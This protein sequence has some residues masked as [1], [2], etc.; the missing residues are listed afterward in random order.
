VRFEKVEFSPTTGPDLDFNSFSSSLGL[1]GSVNDS[2]SVSGLLDMSSRAPTA[3]ELYSNGPHLATNSF[4][5]G[6]TSLSEEDALSLTLSAAYTNDILELDTSV[7]TTKF[8]NYIYEVATDEELDELPVLRWRQDD[9]TFTGFNVKGLVD[10][11][12]FGGGDLSA[13]F[14]LDRVRGEIDSGS[15]LPR[16]PADRRGFGLSWDNSVWETSLDYLNVSNQRRISGFELPT[17][18]YKD[19][20]LFIQRKLVWKNNDVKLFLHGRNLTDEEQ[21]NHSS[22]VKDF[23]PAPGRSWELGVRFDF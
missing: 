19:L 15:D 12:S 22:I 3:E 9:A 11:G 23:A 21:R 8:D 4:E 2:W 16:I 10:L 5:I 1:H 17:A 13:N 14:L 18:S 20:S 7:Y 6:D